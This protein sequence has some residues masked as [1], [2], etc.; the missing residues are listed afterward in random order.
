MNFSVLLAFSNISLAFNRH[1]LFFIERKFLAQ[2][3]ETSKWRA[4]FSYLARGHVGDG[5]VG[6]DGLQLVEAP[7][8][9]LQGLDRRPD[10]VLI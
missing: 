2:L 3:H 9:L 10:V 5:P 8:Q 4:F 1:F 6:L 7:V